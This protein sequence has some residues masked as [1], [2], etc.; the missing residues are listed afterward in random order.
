MD[1]RGIFYRAD[2][3]EDELGFTDLDKVVTWDKL[4]EICAA[5]KEKYGNEGIYGITFPVL[6]AGS[7][8]TMINFCLSNATNWVDATGTQANYQDPKAVETM[9][10]I[11]TL[12]DSGYVPADNSSYDS[13]GAE[14]LYSSGKV[15]M[16]WQSPPAFLYDNPDLLAKTKVMGGVQ[17]PSAD[18]PRLNS[19][20][21]GVM[22][23]QQTEYPDEVREFLEWLPFNNLE[24]STEGGSNA[25][26]IR[27]SFWEEEFY[28]T[29][30]LRSQYCRN[31]EYYVNPVWP[32]AQCMPAFG[33]VEGDGS[34][35]KPLE[36]L[37][38][39]SKDYAGD[40]ASAN[41]SIN[42]AFENYANP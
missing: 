3:L 4:L 40:L 18:K 38:T 31:M 21:N 8:H 14:R 29:D 25:L 28:K 32:S 22:G 20:M 42:N 2:I 13:S 27:K 34:I 35:G 19:W 6:N 30:Y 1:P 10:F 7:M 36:A 33:Q 24:V 17:G 37:L 39:G 12:F 16:V 11:G 23:Y 26:P 15:A 5:V 9:E 41:E